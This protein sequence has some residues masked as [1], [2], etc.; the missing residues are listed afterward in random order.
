M[1]DHEAMRMASALGAAARRHT[2]PWPWVGCVIVSGQRV[3]GCGA[4]GPY[5]GGPHAEVAALADAGPAARGATAYTTLEPCSHHG[6]TPP[7]TEALLDA[8]VRRVVVAISDPDEIVAGRGIRRLS[9][10]GIDVEV[11]PGAASIEASLAPYLHHRRTGRSLMVLKTAMSLDARTSAADGTSQ[12]ITGPAAR[13]DVHRLRAESQAVIVGAGTALADR[14]ALTVRHAPAPARPALRVLLDS[15]GRVDAVGPLF[16]PDLGPTLVLTT[17]RAAAE[18][19]SAWEDRGAE[20][21][22]ALTD[23]HGR[24]DLARLPKL[25]GSRGV[26]QALVEGGAEIHAACLAAGIADRVVAYIAPSW[27]GRNGRLAWSVDGAATIGD[28][29]R[30][31][32]ESVTAIGDDVRMDLIPR[33]SAA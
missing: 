3:V 31:H 27:L 30:W 32:C 9:D 13:T 25:L 11:G 29:P 5:P 17:G 16:D 4:T 26:L 21:V 10:A 23:A 8:G 28:A 2:P 7:C 6:N 12:W 33:R 24:P 22:I 15:A 18:R 14:P 1:H 19:V 20:V